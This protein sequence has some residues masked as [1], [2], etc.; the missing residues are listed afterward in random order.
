MHFPGALMSGLL[1]RR[2]LVWLL[3]G[4]LT[5]QGISVS[6]S[7]ARGPAHVHSKP[8]SILV[9]EDV[10]RGGHFTAESLLVHEW[11]GHSHQ[12]PLRHHHASTDRTVVLEPTNAAV[13]ATEDGVLS[14]DFAVA[15]YVAV[16]ML[17][18]MW[19]P[20]ELSQQ[21]ALH[22]LWQPSFA[23]ARLLERPPQAA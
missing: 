6:F 16:L 22:I 4:F 19:A 7:A 11:W 21:R 12:T 23:T 5:L 2:A 1:S 18:F 14:L 20:A 15:A 17:A 9:L 10:R 8:T 3:V 13:S